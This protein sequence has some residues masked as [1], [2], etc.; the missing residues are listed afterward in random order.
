MHL[1]VLAVVGVTQQRRRSRAIPHRLQTVRASPTN[2][3]PRASRQNA[4]R[5]PP[6]GAHEYPTRE[7]DRRRDSPRLIR[8]ASLF[9]LSSSPS[10]YSSSYITY[11]I[12]TAH[13]QSF[14][15][16]AQADAAQLARLLGFGPKKVA[17]VKDAFER[18]FRTGTTSAL[19]AP[20]TSAS[21]P[22]SAPAPAPAPAP[23]SF[24]S[25]KPHCP[26]PPPPPTLTQH[27][28]K[29]H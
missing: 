23:A 24:A 21:A 27:P 25:T 26:P 16:M 12:G 18:P 11:R 10:L 17:R 19:A 1:L 7:Q 20:S 22:A 29:A 15:K 5:A 9:P 8:C 6:H 4:Q 28:H 2:A 3:H 14:A 13:T